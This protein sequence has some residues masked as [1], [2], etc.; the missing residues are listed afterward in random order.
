MEVHENP[1]EFLQNKCIFDIE[2]IPERSN[3]LIPIDDSD[4][5]YGLCE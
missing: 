2:G 5:N 1:S 3:L 4:D